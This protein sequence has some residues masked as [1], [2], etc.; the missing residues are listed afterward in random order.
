MSEQ[1]SDHP[2]DPTAEVV[3]IC[4]DL[5]RIDTSNYGDNS[6]PG[7]RKAAEHVARLLDEV[8]IESVLHE[9]APGRASLVAR[10]GD[11]SGSEP[12]LLVHGHLDVVP[13]EADDWSHDPFAAEIVDGY[14][15]GRGAV[16]MK[17][18]DAMVL[19]VVRA[20]QRAGV[21]PK[22]PVVLAFTA[23][24]EAGSVYGAH[25]LVDEHSDLVADCTE[26]VGEVGGFSTDVR[27]QRLYVIE[28]GEKGLSWMRLRAEGTA[29]HGSMEQPDNAVTAIAHAVATLGAY[30]WPEQPGPSMRQLLDKVSELTGVDRTDVRALM[31][32]FGP[33]AR[34]I[35]AGMSNVANP[36]MLS[37]GYK[38]NVVP[39]HAEARVDGRYLPGQADSFLGDI[40]TIVGDRVRV[41]ADVFQ[42]A[43]EIPFE[44]DLVDAMT[45]ALNAEDPDAHVAPFLMSGGTDAK[46]WDRL[47]IR[48]YGFTPLRL[49][50]DLDFTALFHGVDERVPTDALEFGA[51][52]FD[53]LVDLA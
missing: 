37:A 28:S 32:E 18:F 16:D 51:R 3:E 24:E 33:A 12:P 52:V 11:H 21:P 36:S 30:E 44:G 48:S 7:E 34:M 13:A 46:A 20:R 10:W 19:S 17:D 14:V 5:I 38:V 26:A 40:Q 8:G 1:P 15:H 41:E 50:A 45:V 23:D 53:R 27:G 43:L 9:S 22:R 49:P 31:A 4:R 35:A 25:W 39:A 29:G 42:P 6:G 47:G 2:Y